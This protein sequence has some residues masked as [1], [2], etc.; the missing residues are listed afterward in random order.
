MDKIKVW[1]EACKNITELQQM[2]ESICSVLNIELTED[3][4]NSIIE[5]VVPR[6]IFEYKKG[7]EI[8]FVN[9][10]DIM[11]FSSNRKQIEIIFKDN[12]RDIFYG[13]LA[14]ISKLL[15]DNFCV[16][17]KSY[18]INRD[19]IKKYRFDEVVMLNNECL[20]ISKP[21]RNNMKTQIS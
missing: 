2:I 5:K 11:Y 21:H 14:D 18:I 17:H 16:I 19:Y 20:R 8:Y 15:P 13:K 6:T 3:E 9:F 1:N 10:H 4:L 7:T 12:H